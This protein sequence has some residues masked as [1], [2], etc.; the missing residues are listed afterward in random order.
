MWPIFF[1]ITIGAAILSRGTGLFIPAV[2]NAIINVWTTG[3]GW[4]FKDDPNW[5]RNNYD[6]IVLFLSAVTTFVGL[7]FLVAAYFLK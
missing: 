3:I 5:P 1:V 7:G 4:N 2:I 6:Q